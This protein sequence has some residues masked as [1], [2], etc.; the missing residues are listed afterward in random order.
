MFGLFGSS[1]P[2]DIDVEKATSPNNTTE[3]WDT[4]IDICDKAPANSKNAKDCIRSIMKRIAHED[5]HVAIQAITLLDACIKNCGKTFHLEVASRDFETEFQRLMVKSSPPVAQKMRVSLKKWAENE[6]KSDHQLNLIPSLYK[7]L[8]NDGLDFKENVVKSKTPTISNDPNVVSSQQEEEDI[9][10]AIELSLQE[11]DVSVKKHSGSNSQSTSTIY[12]NMCLDVK[13]TKNTP[14][15]EGRT[16]RALYDFEAAE[17]N[18]LTFISG[19]LIVVLDDSDENW[20]TGY[21]DRG[22][23][24]FPANFVTADLNINNELNHSQ[25]KMNE[26]GNDEYG[27]KPK[28]EIIQI[29]EM[30]IDRL[31]F[32][33]HEANPEDPTQDTE[34]MFVLEAQVNKM[35][36]LIDSELESVDRNHAKLTQLSTNLVEAI[37]MYHILMRESEGLG[38][39]HVYR[40]QFY[41]APHHNMPIPHSSISHLHSQNHLLDPRYQHNMNDQYRQNPYIATGLASLSQQTP[42]QHTYLPNTVMTTQI[43]DNSQHLPNQQPPL[44]DHHGY[45]LPR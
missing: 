27:S 18:E 6:F 28:T 40:Q 44:H 32:L 29:D 39:P 41:G 38:S 24:L 23:G 30:K 11:K 31:L 16:V 34:E 33:L 19:D 43:Q 42:Q 12:P 25:N 17:D 37:N 1:S 7:K 45:Q 21:N 26:K 15:K 9:A 13:S 35:L 4:I 10:K 36:P 8:L 22:E 5:P 2:F 3:Q 14:K 20:W